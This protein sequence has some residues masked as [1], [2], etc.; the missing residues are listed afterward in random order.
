MRVPARR[1]RANTDDGAT[2]NWAPAGRPVFAAGCRLDQQYRS[3]FS[4]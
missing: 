1:D 3:S 4:Q 2:G